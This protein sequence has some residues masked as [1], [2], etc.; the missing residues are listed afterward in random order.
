MN[1][2]PRRGD[3]SRAGTRAGRRPRARDRRSAGQSRSCASSFTHCARVT[4]AKKPGSDR[5]PSSAVTRAALLGDDRIARAPERRAA[6]LVAHDQQAHRGADL[7]RGQA[8]AD[9]VV[10]RVDHVVDQARESRASPSSI[11]DCARRRSTRI[12]VTTNLQDG[13]STGSTS[14][15]MIPRA[16]GAAAAL[17]SSSACASA[18]GRSAS[19]FTT[20]APRARRARVGDRR[21]DGQPRR[22]AHPPPATSSATRCVSAAAGRRDREQREPA[23]RRIAAARA[24]NSSSRA[25]EAG[26]DPGGRR[27]SMA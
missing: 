14:T 10:H 5:Q 26:R 3:R 19:P 24:R 1:S 21:M 22:G 7:R 9:L 23:E 13:H 8:D 15:S 2:T 17:K 12:T 25:I 16:D 4:G 6:V 20:T 11:G 27:A 18:A